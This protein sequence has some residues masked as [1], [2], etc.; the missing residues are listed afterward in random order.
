[1]VIGPFDGQGD[2]EAND[3]AGERPSINAP[4]PHLRVR[5]FEEYRI[6][7]NSELYLILAT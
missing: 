3:W 1:M 6:C 2:L 7:Y 5:F 4:S